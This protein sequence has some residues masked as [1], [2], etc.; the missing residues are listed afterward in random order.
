MARIDTRIPNYIIKCLVFGFCIAMYRKLTILSCLAIVLN[1][2]TTGPLY[3]QDE[4]LDKKVV[5]E[6]PSLS[7]PVVEEPEETEEQPAEPAPKR[8]AANPSSQPTSASSSSTNQSVSTTFN[9]TE[10]INSS[11]PQQVVS[12][13]AGDNQVQEAGVN[14]EEGNVLGAQ[15]YMAPE[16]GHYLLPIYLI[17]TFVVLGFGILGI[18]R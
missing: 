15:D 17:V 3:A 12:E 1:F 11:Q 10:T 9:Q 2:I 13:E 16:T 6:Q 14:N 7:D 8:E 18:K 4:V 5:S